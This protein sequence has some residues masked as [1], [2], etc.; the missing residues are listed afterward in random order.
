[1]TDYETNVDEGVLDPEVAK[2]LAEN[3]QVDWSEGFPPEI[4]EAA[5]NYEGPPPTRHI[6]RVNDDLVGSVPIRIYRNARSP[7]GLIVYF[8]GGAFTV[9]SVNIMDGVAR[10][11]THATEAVVVSVDYRL[12]PEHPFPAG[13]DDCLAVTKWALANAQG[14][15]VP[16]AAVVVAGESAGGNLATAVTL[17]L[18]DEGVTTVGGQ[19][20]IYPATDGPKASYP[21]REQF[22]HSDWV[23]DAY[24]GGRD[25]SDEPYAVPMS[26]ASLRGLPPAL[27]LLAGCDML[28]DEG[29][30]YARRMQADGVDVEEYCFAGQPHGFVN[31]ALPAAAQV[32]K[33]MARWM[34]THVPV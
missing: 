2:W 24:G 7:S 30:A 4:L 28:R 17:R 27:V 3:P 6:D 10:E 29:R 18:R 23:W 25:L 34:R 16:P 12:A 20:L 32:Y 21:S 14:L 22:G 1:M 26:A 33:R 8:H 15:G 31:F 13:F 5:R 9:G 19:I 11:I